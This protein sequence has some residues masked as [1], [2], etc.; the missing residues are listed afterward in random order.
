MKKSS[1]KSISLITFVTVFFL[2]SAGPAFSQDDGL[3]E[4]LKALESSTMKHIEVLTDLLNKVPEQAKPSIEHAIAVSKRGRRVAIEAVDIAMTSDPLR[5]ASLYI[6]HSDR[7]LADIQAMHHKG[8]PDFIETLAKDYESAIGGATDNINKAAA[9]GRDVTKPL[10][11]VESS[12]KKHTEVLTKLLMEKVAEQ[13]KPAIAHALKTSLHGR[14]Q[15][16]A[17]L[18]KMQKGEL[19]TNKTEGIRRPEIVNRPYR[20]VRPERPERPGRP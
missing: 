18:N 11:T 20:P 2:F 19:S 12:T 10:K 15:A 6:T 13:A 4:A 5:K 3:S 14:K 16:L 1:A 9:R 7:R 8:K 17:V